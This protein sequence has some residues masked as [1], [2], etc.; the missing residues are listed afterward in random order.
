MTK[1]QKD[2]SEGPKDSLKD[3]LKGN[4]RGLVSWLTDD[5]G[6]CREGGD[7]GEL[8]EVR[9]RNLQLEDENALLRNQLQEARQ[10]LPAPVRDIDE[11]VA[12]RPSFRGQIDRYQSQLE[13]LDG[14][15][16]DLASEFPEEG[17]EFIDIHET[18]HKRSQILR[19]VLNGMLDKPDRLNEWLPV[20]T[21]K[22]NEMEEA[23]K[24]T[25]SRIE[26]LYG[27]LQRKNLETHFSDSDD[28]SKEGLPPKDEKEFLILS[29]ENERL[30]LLISEKDEDLSKL[31]ALLKYKEEELMRREEDLMYRERLMEESKKKF[32]NERKSLE[33]LDAITLEKRLEHLRREIQRKEEE[34]IKKEKY[35]ASKMEE[36]RNMELGLIEDE[37]DLRD[38]ERKKE[39]SINKVHTGNQRFNDLLLGGYP[40]GSNI[41]LHGPA[42]VGKEVLLNEFMAEG[43]KKGIPVLWVITDKTC[44]D[45][46]K[47][48]EIVLP[49]YTE[50]EKLNLVRYVDNYSRSIGD[51]DEDPYTTYIEDPGDHASLSK[52]VDE[53]T[54]QFLKDHEYYRLGFQS[55]S[56]F[57]A[58]SDSASAFRFL[59][60]FVGKRRKSKAVCL[61]LL[62]KGMHGEQDI[63]ML[64]MIMDGMVEF[65][66]DQMRTFLTVNG[67]GD[68]QTR[69]N[70]RYNW[71]NHGLS[72][73]SF[74]LDHIK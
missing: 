47:S 70:V 10:G 53:V 15:L 60:P 52:A 37:I 1:E 57:I 16:Q 48:M 31:R 13:S 35:L 56:T 17:R 69:G 8:F 3:W 64:G 67:V 30:L 2:L 22:G 58:Y 65:N 5:K 24:T 14:K 63:Q 74:T 40:F 41:I 50:Y 38:E 44:M 68:V 49:G 12:K 20:L 21:Q 45:I 11:L 4:D 54:N 73:G 27:L 62:E 9:K 7:D 6:K 46:R 51:S 19:D 32:D 42:F 39:I 43:L 29:K 72:I 25:I 66:V 34:M 28:D 18:I 26:N 59:S 23:Y 61:Y 71:S 33:G 55:L 36:L